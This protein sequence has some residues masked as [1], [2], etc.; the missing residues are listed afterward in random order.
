MSEYDYF[1]KLQECIIRY[2]QE[3]EEHGVEQLEIVA[4]TYALKDP[5]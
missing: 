2:E 4:P 1:V 3:C 5:R